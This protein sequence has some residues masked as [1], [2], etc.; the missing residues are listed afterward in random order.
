MG[1]IAW[2]HNFFPVCLIL[3][4]TLLAAMIANIEHDSHAWKFLFALP[5]SKTKLFLSKLIWIH[6]IIL[7]A[8]L[9][10]A[11][12]LIL[13][14]I[15]IGLGDPV[16]WD[17]VFQEM[18]YPYLAAFPV[19][20]IQFGLSMSMKNQSLP[21]IIGSL[22]A[23]TSLF[24]AYNSSGLLPYLFPWAYVPL[25]SP[26]LEGNYT[27]WPIIGVNIGII[28]FVLITTYITKRDI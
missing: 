8:V 10:T 19:L 3:G 9:L 6:L 18:I 20:S 14:G 24:V 25:A 7:T 17:L 16:R 4:I 13:L 2:A 27:Q 21:I 1:F 11:I 15:L 26:L 22:G 23:M 5:I 28:L 12:G